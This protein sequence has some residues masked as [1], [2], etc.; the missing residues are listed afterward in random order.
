MVYIFDEFDKKELIRY[1]LNDSEIMK[2]N[3]NSCSASTLKMPEE[4]YRQLQSG[5]LQALFRRISP[6]H[7]GAAPLPH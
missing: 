5:S 2:N 4:S 6:V 1:S 7:S 3:K